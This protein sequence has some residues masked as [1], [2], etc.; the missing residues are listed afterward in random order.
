MGQLTEF[1]LVVQE[2]GL[3]EDSYTTSIRLR[4]WVKQN[5]HRRYVPEH[6]LNQWGLE[7]DPWALLNY[8]PVKETA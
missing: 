4:T 1:E 5:R 6:L 2:L 8:I 7:V 3:S